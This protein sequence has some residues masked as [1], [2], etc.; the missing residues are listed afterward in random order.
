[1]KFRVIEGGKGRDVEPTPPAS[2]VTELALAPAVSGEACPSLSPSA[3]DVRREARTGTRMEPRLRYLGLQID[4]VAEKLVS[5]LPIPE[6]FAS[7][8][9]W[10]ATV[11]LANI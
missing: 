9:Y 3:A 6:D 10:P 1:M 8:I 7:D 2:L 11:G 5:L 4:L